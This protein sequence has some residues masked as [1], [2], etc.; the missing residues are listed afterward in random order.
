MQVYFLILKHMAVIRHPVF[1]KYGWN[2][3]TN[4]V[5]SFYVFRDLNTVTMFSLHDNHKVFPY[6]V[7]RFK[8]ECLHNVSLSEEY[9]V[10]DDVLYNSEND[11]I[12]IGS[13]TFIRSDKFD[14]VYVNSNKDFIYIPY[15]RLIRRDSFDDY[16]NPAL[17][18]IM[19]QL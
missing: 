17:S 18:R 11:R 14:N 5:F 3:E 7:S 16:N 15:E 8:Y 19:E 13:E 4:K 1:K 2:T 6:N 12:I 10:I 9:F